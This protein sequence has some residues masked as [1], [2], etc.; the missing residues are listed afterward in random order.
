[1]IKVQNTTREFGYFNHTK[2][3]FHCKEDAPFPVKDV[4]QA[5]KREIFLAVEKQLVWRTASVR[6]GTD[7]DN[8]VHL[9]THVW[10]SYLTLCRPNTSVRL[11]CD[12]FAMDLL[13]R[14]AN[15]EERRQKVWNI[16]QAEELG[17]FSGLLPN[18]TDT[19]KES[20]S[21]EK[22]HN[23]VPSTWNNVCW[24]VGKLRDWGHWI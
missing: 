1:M 21:K 2:R 18:T 19:N 23:G 14:F 9:R 17:I 8:L 24:S 3:K 11:H 20:W 22:L 16:P 10:H 7:Y 13:L 12:I 5:K 15:A 4:E 6:G